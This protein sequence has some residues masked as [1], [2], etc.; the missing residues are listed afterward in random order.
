MPDSLVELW[1]LGVRLTSADGAEF[2]GICFAS[3]TAK[4]T[5]CATAE[6][7]F[8][9]GIGVA[10]IR[11]HEKLV[12][13]ARACGVRLH[14]NT[15]ARLRAGQPVA[16]DGEAF[17]YRYLVGA[18]GQGSAV[19]RWAGL[20]SGT[21]LSSRFG[22]RM[23]FRVGS[24]SNVVEVHW[25]QAGEVYVTPVGN[26][27]I[28]VAGITRDPTMRLQGLLAT[29]PVL[30]K[31]LRDAVI[32]SRECGAVTTTRILERTATKDVALVGDASGSVDA[33]T[34]EGLAICFRQATLLADAIDRGDL[35]SYAAGHPKTV[36]LPQR[37]ASLM[38][39][40]D[41]WPRFRERVIRMLAEDPAMF[42]RILGVH[43]GDESMTHFLRKRGLLLGLRLL[44][45][46]SI[47]ATDSAEVCS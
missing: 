4:R 22:F 6:F 45:P 14:W 44:I 23:H 15:P 3:H 5:E 42:R 20:D 10:R 33:V 24:W 36:E 47:P 11:L 35:Y 29:L 13:H 37:M 7:A 40:M 26:G 41:R 2:R 9:A 19:R 32:T 30:W 39:M 16:I 8:G 21:L 43:V 34:G 17:S 18:D 1:R 27:T 31:K 38:L 25:G 12:E 28:C 46:G